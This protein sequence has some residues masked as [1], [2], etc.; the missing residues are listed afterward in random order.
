MHRQTHRHSKESIE[1]VHWLLM[2]AMNGI[3][4][5]PNQ[6]IATTNCS[7]ILLPCLDLGNFSS[8]CT[9]LIILV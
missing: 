8:K 9:A 2:E 1:S 5:K 4:N 7:I 6:T 3:A